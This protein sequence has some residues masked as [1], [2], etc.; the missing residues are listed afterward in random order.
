VTNNRY[1]YFFAGIWILALD[2]TLV[3]WVK[4]DL[5]MAWL[6]GI[7]VILAGGAV[8]GLAPA[9]VVR[10]SKRVLI[11]VCA[12]TL[13]SVLLLYAAMKT[14]HQ[15]VSAPPGGLVAAANR[16]AADRAAIKSAVEKV[17]GYPVEPDIPAKA[18]LTNSLVKK[19]GFSFSLSRTPAS[20]LVLVGFEAGPAETIRFDLFG[21]SGVPQMRP[22]KSDVGSIAIRAV[23]FE[24]AF[25]DAGAIEVGGDGPYSR[26]QSLAVRAARSETDW[27]IVILRVM[28]GN[29]VLRE[30]RTYSRDELLSRFRGTLAAA[31]LGPLQSAV[32][33]FRPVKKPEVI[34]AGSSA[35]RFMG[36]LGDPLYWR[37]EVV[38]RLSGDGS[39]MEFSVGRKLTRPHAGTAPAG[40]P[41]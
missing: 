24:R 19:Q 3:W 28:D 37:A 25:P 9:V 30:V 8:I 5:E 39:T 36:L 17:T 40:D 18:E 13:L 12:S 31:E 41:R 27:S 6:I 29:R 15:W 21:S 4:G 20:A 16:F 26:G 35:F 14:P 2:G 33:Y 22:L 7:P 38:A 10:E 34:F 1:G 23:S 11:S 32:I